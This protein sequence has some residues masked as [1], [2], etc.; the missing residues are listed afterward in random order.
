MDVQKWQQNRGKKKKGKTNVQ[1]DKYEAHK[2]DL[3][4]KMKRRT[5][6]NVSETEFRVLAYNMPAWV[7]DN[8]LQ[9][10]NKWK[11]KIKNGV[12]YLKVER[13]QFIAWIWVNNDTKLVFLI[14]SHKRLLQISHKWNFHQTF[15]TFSFSFSFSFSRT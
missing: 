1:R 12:M 3:K 9:Q 11:I 7:A 13:T 8:R 6:K 14:R 4:W 15:F 2:L 10:E 5:W